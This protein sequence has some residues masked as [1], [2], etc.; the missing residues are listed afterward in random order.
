VGRENLPPH[1]HRSHR[2]Y[3]PQNLPVFRKTFRDLKKQL[4]NGLSLKKRL[5]AKA[6]VRRHLALGSGK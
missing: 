3:P 5:H 6:S 4:Q 1:D 2:T